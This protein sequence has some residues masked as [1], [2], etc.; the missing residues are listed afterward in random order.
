M[1]NEGVMKKIYFSC[2]ALGF[3]FNVYANSDL[4]PPPPTAL[5]VTH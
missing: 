3:I 1:V 5:E 2:L 4:I